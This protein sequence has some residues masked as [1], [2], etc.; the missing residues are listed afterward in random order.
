TAIRLTD[1]GRADPVLSQLGENT[2]QF[3]WHEDTFALPEGAA[4]LAETDICPRQA[5]R[6]KENVYGVQFHPEV[7]LATIQQ[8]LTMARSLPEA[9]G[10]A[11][12]EE[13]RAHYASRFARSQAMFS[14]FLTQAYRAPAPMG[15]PHGK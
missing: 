10:K 7:N 3:Q 9:T 8:W 13:T 1:A 6:V 5:Y 12:W 15:A 2:L 14:A 11:I 4:L